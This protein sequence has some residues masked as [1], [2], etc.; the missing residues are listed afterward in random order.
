LSILDTS[1]VIELD[2][3]SSE[4]MLRSLV[5]GLKTGA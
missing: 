2:A 1:G 4:I 3:I 5:A